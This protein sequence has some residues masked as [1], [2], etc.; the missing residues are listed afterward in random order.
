MTEA[1]R[2]DADAGAADGV[3]TGSRP[4]A[5]IANIRRR[6]ILSR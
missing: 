2:G 1:A 3:M 5:L 6:A 4:M